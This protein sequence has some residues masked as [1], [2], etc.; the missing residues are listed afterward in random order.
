MPV[1][2]FSPQAPVNDHTSGA[3]KSN[4]LT[5]SI[6]SAA[7]LY[8]GY[9]KEKQTEQDIMTMQD[10]KSSPIQR[11]V[12]AVR[13]GNNPLAVEFMKQEN[14]AQKGK[15]ANMLGDSLNRNLQQFRGEVPQGNE[16]QNQTVS[17]TQQAGGVPSIGNLMQQ[18]PGGTQ[19]TNQNQPQKNRSP[20]E[21]L[22]GE[23]KIYADA[24]QQA[25]QMGDKDGA[26]KY[27]H[28]SDKLNEEANATLQ[29][30]SRT[31]SA[32]V[33]T[34]QRKEEKRVEQILPIQKEAATLSKATDT[35]LRSLDDQLEI[36]KSGKVNPVS[37]ANFSKFLQER[38]FD[39]A[40][41]NAFQTPGGAL[42]NTA[43]KEIITA[44]LKPAFGARPL[45]VEFQAVVDMLAQTGRSKEANELTIEALK[46]PPKIDNAV[47][48]FT[49]R[50][51]KENPNISP[52][53]VN[54]L[55][56]DYREE[57]TDTIKSDWDMKMKSM[58]ETEKVSRQPSVL[59]GSRQAQVQ[60]PK[61]AANH[62]LM[63]APNGNLYQ[64]P[65]SKIQSKLLAGGEIVNE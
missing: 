42:F 8:S 6:S 21:M 20:I 43:G 16:S 18:I 29:A 13:S 36:V 39:K 47:A 52:I 59:S 56:H 1:Y 40:I 55:A 32:I 15:M 31:D 45:G 50:K 49:M 25:S 28:I 48:K 24:A 17:P 9:K 12:A 64:V 38:G 3:E 5:N 10:P 35:S 37:K 58:L 65:A 23:A 60:K 46:I 61:L 41:V 62:V 33:K 30:Q 27:M 4:I 44:T 22:R 7:N 34:N 11:A 2:A 54:S 53:E 57:I 14:I 26:S 63:K 51:I 19:D